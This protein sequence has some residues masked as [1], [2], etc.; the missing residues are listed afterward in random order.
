MKPLLTALVSGLFAVTAFG[1]DAQSF[2]NPDEDAG[3]ELLLEC[4]M[5]AGPCQWE[6]IVSAWSGIGPADSL[7]VNMQVQ[8]G[9][10][11]AGA[12]HPSE[13]RWGNPRGRIVTCSDTSPAISE[14][15]HVKTVSLRTLETGQPEGLAYMRVCYGTDAYGRPFPGL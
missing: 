3:K 4:R 14:N 12:R 8:D 13:I 15:G 2:R 1:A 10:S 11:P 9:F 5:P 7:I 6:R